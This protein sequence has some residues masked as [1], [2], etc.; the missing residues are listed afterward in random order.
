MVIFLTGASGFIGLH[1]SR[2]LRE[3]GHRV[4]E[5][6]REA[7][8]P[9]QHVQ[10]DFTRDVRADDW[11]PKLQGV[12]CVINA[13]GILRE[14][15]A[16]T[17]ERIH[18]LAPRALFEAC[19]QVGVQRII[20]ISALGADNGTSG[21]FRSKRA[22]DEFL[23]TLPLEWT[24]V[25]PSVVYGPGGSSARLFTMLASLPVIPLPGRGTQSIQPVH[26]DDVVACILA[27]LET[28]APTR[29]RIPL[30]GPDALE[31]REFLARLREAMGMRRTVSIPIPMTLMRL[32][33]QMGQWLPRSLLDRETLAMLEAGNTADP[34]LTRHLLGRDPRAVEAFVEPRYRGATLRQAQLVWLLPLLRFSI[35]AVWIWTGIVSLGLYP[36]TESYA[37]LA[38]VG[39][40]DTL[41]PILL[42][43]AALLDFAFGIAILALPRRRLLW[44]AQIALILGYTAII[45]VKLPEFWLHPFGPLLKN[46]PMVVGIYVLYVLEEK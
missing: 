21:Y 45:S 9:T 28:D 39:V 35:A 13:V 41:A 7:T 31:L 32:S 3:A 43:G 44:L 16:Q 12:E 27:L 6:R 42:Y 20:Q 10:A 36:V 46:I 34:A 1:L 30:V 38:R 40:D 8:D 18:T 23:Q 5:A 15:S 17:F 2:A 14:R 24:I 25:Q 37:L 33:A 19:A 11:V 29:L 4:I 22:A 26:I